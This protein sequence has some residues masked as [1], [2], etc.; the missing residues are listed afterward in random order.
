MS[1]MFSASS[2]NGDIRS[3]VPKDCRDF[4]E[5]FS[6]TSAFDQDISRWVVSSAETMD[7]MFYR[8]A[9]FS[10][11]LCWSS[12]PRGV[13]GTSIMC[14]SNGG[15]FDWLCQDFPVGFENG[16]EEDVSESNVPRNF[17]GASKPGAGHGGSGGVG[18]TASG[19]P[20]RDHPELTANA[21]SGPWGDEND[22]QEE[23]EGDGNEDVVSNTITLENNAENQQ[24]DLEV[25][26]VQEEA[27]AANEWML[28][29]T[30]STAVTV[31]CFFLFAVL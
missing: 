3:W 19:L 4:T 9:A 2:F 10:E 1:Y 13:S 20:G 21:E 27:S 17:G 25:S 14:E 28:S 31:A 26:D 23:S 18:A 11:E 6:Y 8:A 30:S 22:G 7:F 5:M 29:L 24:A 16:C 12:L 15:S